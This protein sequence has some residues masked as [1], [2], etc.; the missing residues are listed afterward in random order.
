VTQLDDS[1]DI[2]GESVWAVP[3]HLR[4]E[5]LA[6]LSMEPTWPARVTYEQFLEW[7]DEDS[8]AEWV[9]GRVVVASPENIGHESLRAFLRETLSRY[10]SLN[11]LGRVVG[12]AVQMKLPKSGREPDVL[13]VATEHLTRFRPTYLD[14]P[15]DVVIEIVSP[16]SAARDRG[17]KFYDYLEGG[18]PE[19][20]LL[21][22]ELRQADFYRL[23]G[24]GRYQLV[25]LEEG[26]IFRSE[27]LPGFWMR[28]DWLWQDPRPDPVTVLMEIDRDGY[29]K[30]LKRILGQTAGE[31]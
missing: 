21:D 30:H 27:T 7:A 9:D 1:P 13:Y 16:E 18:I 22:P 15:A 28:T 24:S 6:A 19:Y 3:A 23:D 2:Q 25:Q 26:G 29:R 4:L 14:G 5:L 10:V 17:E 8:R 12:A 31:E 11:S 20:W